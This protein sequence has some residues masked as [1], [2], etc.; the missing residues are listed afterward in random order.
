MKMFKL[1]NMIAEINNS[2]EGFENK[3]QEISHKNRQKN[4]SG[5]LEGEKNIF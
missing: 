2:I 1:G 3:V 4:I 5:K